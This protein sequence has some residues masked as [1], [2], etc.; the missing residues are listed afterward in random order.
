MNTFT[1]VVQSMRPPFLLLTPV[2]ILLGVGSA[3]YAGY[4]IDMVLF[5]LILSGALA[6]HI[7]VNTMNEYMDFRS[8]LDLQTQKTPFSGG[9]GALPRQPQAAKAILM[10]A[11]IS[12]AVTVLIGLYFISLRGFSILPLGLLGISIIVFY[13]GEINRHPFLCLLAPGIGFGP[14]MV[15]G[16]YFVLTGEYSWQVAIVS[17][18]PLFLVS[19]LLLLNQYPDIEADKRVGRNHF[20]IAYGIEKSNRVYAVFLLLAFMTLLFA[21]SKAYLPLSSL[22]SLLLFLTAGLALKGAMEYSGKIAEF[23]PYMGLNVA[24]ALLMPLFLG[25]SQMFA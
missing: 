8:G 7:S 10:M 25:V 17:L 15:V 6:A 24:T 18:I 5:M 22:I 3:M 21:V 23:Q 13:T 20:P 11:I 2:C 19:N 9:S 12:L 16:T 4:S 1:A 14:L